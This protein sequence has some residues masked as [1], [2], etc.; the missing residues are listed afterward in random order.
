MVAH[1]SVK[2]G[3]RVLGIGTD[4]VHLSRFSKLLQKYPLSVASASEQGTFIKIAKKFMHSR[5]IANLQLL[6]SETNN[7]KHTATYIAGIWAIKESVLKAFSS[8]VPGPEMPTAQCIYTRLIYKE[9]KSSGRPI[10][11]FDEQFLATASDSELQF[12]HKYIKTP[13]T[14][15][16]VSISHDEDYLVTFVCLVEDNGNGNGHA[17]ATDSIFDSASS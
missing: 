6:V 8:F 16:I 12:Y 3:S 7:D 14:R 13:K 4:I 15:P 9:K 5:E 10:L 2:A 17:S 1:L 11:R